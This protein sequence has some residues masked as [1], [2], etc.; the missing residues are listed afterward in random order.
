VDGEEA[1]N[2]VV[3]QDPASTSLLAEGG[4]INVNVSSGGRGLKQVK[5]TIPMPK[6]IDWLVKVQAVIDGK[7]VLEETV[8]PNYVKYWYPNFE[9]NGTVRRLFWW[10]D[11]SIRN[12]KSILRIR[13]ISAFPTIRAISDDGRGNRGA[14]YPF[15]RRVLRCGGGGE[16]HCPL[17]RPGT[18]S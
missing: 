13:V 8:Q 14:D 16:N 7:V 15:Q 17:P 9:G 4:M 18:F 11:S 1:Y 2:T 6:R 10:T 3:A 12:M 5:I